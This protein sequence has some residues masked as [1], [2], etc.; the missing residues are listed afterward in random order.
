L[1]KADAQVADGASFLL[2]ADTRLSQ[3]L[4][5]GILVLEGA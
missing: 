3:A 4:R 2:V 1:V 5:F